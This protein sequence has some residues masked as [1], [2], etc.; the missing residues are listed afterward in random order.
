MVVVSLW[1]R[2][3]LVLAVPHEKEEQVSAPL[4]MWILNAIENGGSLNV[5][6]VGKW[7]Y[8]KMVWPELPNDDPIGATNRTLE[9]ALI[10]LDGSLQEDA[11]KEMQN[12]PNSGV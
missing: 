2:T 6:K 4:G 8:A 7:Y 10:D 5:S 9:G 1:F 12:N 11:A 3:R